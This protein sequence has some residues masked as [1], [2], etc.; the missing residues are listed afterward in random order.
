MALR[1][2]AVWWSLVIAPA[3]FGGAWVGCATADT[4]VDVAPKR[5]PRDSSADET[6][7]GDEVSIDPDGGGPLCPGKTA[8]PNSC[9]AATDLGTINAGAVKNVEDGIAAVAGD[10]WY[11]VTFADLEKLTA[12]PRIVLS[13]ADANIF[14][15]VNKTCAGE[16]ATCGEE[17]STAT[18]VKDY[19]V[20][21]TWD[22]G[23]PEDKTEV[24]PE[25]GV[26]KPIQVGEMGTVYI[27]VYRGS[28]G[29]KTGCNFKL[30]ITN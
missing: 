27:R 2:S 18:K 17:G 11:K 26:F 23:M 28:D 25:A 8:T 9:A 12:H 3:M 6:S 21:Y 1:S 30:D 5:P 13:S 22:G 24:G 20:R 7:T 29:A 16:L 15:E 4:E 19:E 10:I 14:L